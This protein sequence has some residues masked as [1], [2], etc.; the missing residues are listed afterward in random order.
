MEHCRAWSA[1]QG[2]HRGV[3]RAAL[4]AAVCVLL[5]WAGQL[6]FAARLP[7]GIGLPAFAL[8]ASAGA[9]V[10]SRKA[11]TQRQAL[12]ALVGSQI[13]FHAAYTLPGACSPQH[14]LLH[15]PGASG[16]LPGEAVIGHVVAVILA[17]RLLGVCEAALRPLRMLAHAARMR[18][19]LVLH[20]VPVVV[21]PLVRVAG[22]G[23]GWVPVGFRG[24]PAWGTRAPPRG[25]AIPPDR[26]ARL[27][28]V[29]GSPALA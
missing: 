18:L 24:P 21:P 20:A 3:V 9:V 12:G 6:E 13:A 7:S 14:G 15:E 27:P 16:H 10:V 22:D 17:V 1:P 26:S 23:R 19:S 28:A 2:R 4:M 25:V 8:V 29:F 11:V 5:P